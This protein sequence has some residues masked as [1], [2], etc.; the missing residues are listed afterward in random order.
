M[1]DKRM[2]FFDNMEVLEF[3]AY[4]NKH[5]NMINRSNFFYHS[6]VDMLMGAYANDEI[7]E[8][9]FMIFNDYLSEVY[10]DLFK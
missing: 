9:E 3:C 8:H 5:L 7:T 4:Y 6:M 10:N 1:K 2:L